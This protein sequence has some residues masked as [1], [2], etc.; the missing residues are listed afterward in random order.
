MRQFTA[1][2][3]LV[4]GSWSAAFGQVPLPQPPSVQVQP[5]PAPQPPHP[6]VHPGQQ[7]LPVQPVQQVV[8]HVDVIEVSRARLK[9]RGVAAAA[10]LFRNP[11]AESA[12][13][14]EKGSSTYGATDAKHCREILDSLRKDGMV[15]VLSEPTIVTTAGRPASLHVGGMARVVAKGPDGELSAETKP[16]GTEVDALPVFTAEGNVRLAL[17]VEVSQLSE[18]GAMMVRGEKV[19]IRLVRRFDSPQVE[20][21]PGQTVVVSGMVSTRTET[22]ARG[23][24]FLKDIPY[25]GVP[26]RR[27]RQRTNEVE[28]LV[29]VTADLGNRRE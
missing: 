27:V 11:Q 6:V 16:I 14:I 1:I 20:M 26:F 24:P 19:P 8:V 13:F 29:L 9:A 7:V 25:L 18:A 12:P 21:K 15:K 2:L 22:E 10:E 5:V 3:C 4:F 17:R 23:V 28:L